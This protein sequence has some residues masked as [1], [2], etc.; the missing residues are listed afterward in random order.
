ML[1]D[2]NVTADALPHVSAINISCTIKLKES[3][4]TIT[5]L[6]VVNRLNKEEPP[7]NQT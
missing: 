4:A 3:V 6:V 5:Y 7:V 2:K 1:G